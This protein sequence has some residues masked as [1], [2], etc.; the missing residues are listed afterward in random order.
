MMRGNGLIAV[1]LL[2]LLGMGTQVR[3]QNDPPFPGETE[4]K[5]TATGTLLKDSPT[6]LGFA[7]T[8]N[9]KKAVYKVDCDARNLVAVS[10]LK[11]NEKVSVVFTVDATGQRIVSSVEKLG[12]A[13]KE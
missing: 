9:D 11:A 8:E 2:G 7:L 4:G 13:P 5:H 10:R 3:A 12:D 1:V 6:G